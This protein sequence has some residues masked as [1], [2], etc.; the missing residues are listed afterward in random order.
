MSKARLLRGFGPALI[1]L[2][3]AWAAALEAGETTEYASVARDSNDE[4]NLPAA[5]SYPSASS[6]GAAG[7]LQPVGSLDGIYPDEPAAETPKLSSEAQ[8]PP[9]PKP[10][11]QSPPQPWKGV[12]YDNDF[13]YMHDPEH[14]PLFGEELKELE[15]CPDHW[16]SYGGEL[17][18]RF[19]HEDNRLRPGFPKQ[20]N[21]Q[22]WRWRQYLDYHFGEQ[23][24][25]YIEVIDASSF[26]E[27]LP[28]LNIDEDRFDITNAFFDAYLT[29]LGADQ[30]LVFRFGRQELLY[31]QQRLISP[32]DWGNTRRTFEG[33]KLL[34]RGP[35]WDIDLFAT[36][37]VNRFFRSRNKPDASRTFS[38]AYAIYHGAEHDQFDF[39]W[40]WDREQEPVPTLAD[41]SRHTTGLN[42]QHDMPV[43]DCCGEV[44]R[45][46]A[47]DF[48]GA[49]QFGHDNGQTVQAGFVT[50]GAGHTW[51]N[52]PWQ[53]SLWGFFDWA[54]GDHD[55]AD[56]ENNT[57]NQLFPLGHAYLGWFDAVGRQN[58]IDYNVR[59]S[60]KPCE[61]LTLTAWMH[62]FELDERKDAL[63]NAGGAPFA[64][65]ATGGSSKDVGE[66]LDLTAKYVICPNADVLLGYSWFWP[67]DFLFDTDRAEKGQTLYIQTTLR[68]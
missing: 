40:I 35:Q 2:V 3:A 51:K 12:F 21:Y 47:L 48:E 30:P 55:P 58:I 33:F 25:A 7:G 19:M 44:T 64:R 62:W 24:R 36:R 13:S 46:W 59:L 11:K 68:Y 4:V 10:K 8:L 65:D 5:P 1:M 63:Y 43:T 41:G 31:G 49:Y 29:D 38:G 39:Y 26:N 18:F 32:L 66:E 6:T 16:F 53:P 61:K 20:N 67:G 14:T 52:V 27:N 34:S 22:L 23:L 45:V 50:A 28:P 54:S 37:P 17:R 56:D 9:P 57:F 42:W 15:I 60:A